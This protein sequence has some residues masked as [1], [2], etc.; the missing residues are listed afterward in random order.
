MIPAELRE[1]V[2]EKYRGR[3]RDASQ[4]TILLNRVDKH[5]HKGKY[6]FKKNISKEY[7]KVI[8]KMHDRV[9]YELLHY[10]FKRMEEEELGVFLPGEFFIKAHSSLPG[11][12][13]VFI[14]RGK[15]FYFNLIKEIQHRDQFSEHWKMDYDLKALLER[16]LKISFSKQQKDL[17]PPRFLFSFDDA[18]EGE[19]DELSKSKAK[20]FIDRFIEVP[21]KYKCVEEDVLY[22]IENKVKRKIK[23][24]LSNRRELFNL[25]GVDDHFNYIPSTEIRSNPTQWMR[26]RVSDFISNP[27][28]TDDF[29][30]YEDFESYIDKENRENAEIYQ[31]PVESNIYA[32]TL[33]SFI[34]ETL[35]SKKYISS[36][37]GAFDV[38]TNSP[39]NIS[40]EDS[41]EN[42]VDKAIM[43]QGKNSKSALDSFLEFD[44]KSYIAPSKDVGFLFRATNFQRP[45]FDRFRRRILPALSSMIPPI[46]GDL[47]PR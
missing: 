13:S 21:E 20:E 31:I 9:R 32:Q 5:L 28:Y 8:E 39:I 29:T 19:I 6:H 2:Y 38:H 44:V 15:F 7:R 33:C 16:E 36:I 24:V 30:F 40:Y 18:D 41:S 45:F 37:W 4:I 34:T 47:V 1:E 27:V 26:G 22:R 25:K 17:S 46:T 35:T 23:A 43:E 10:L 3:I 11:V 42:P 12:M 14:P